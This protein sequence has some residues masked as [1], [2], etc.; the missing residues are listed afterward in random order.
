MRRKDKRAFNLAWL[1]VESRGGCDSK[2]SFEYQYVLWVWEGLGR[3]R[4]ISPF[5]WNVANIPPDHQ[6]ANEVN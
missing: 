2:G 4:P 6:Y 3:P 5:I 1:K